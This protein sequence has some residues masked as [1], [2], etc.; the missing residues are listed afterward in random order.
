VKISLHS[1]SYAGLWGQHYLGVGDF[2]DKAAELGYDGVM[3]TAKRPHLSVLD[4]MPKELASLRSRIEAKNLRAVCLAGYTNFSADLD[5]SDIPLI[6]MQIA[7]VTELARMAQALDCPSVRIFTAYD[8][9]KA[10]WSTLVRTL[11]EC[12]RRAAPTIVGVQNHHDIAVDYETLFDLISEVD[13]PNCRAMF[14][15]WAPAIH[16]ADLA[17]AAKRMA[18]IT[19]HTT[20]ANYQPRP[21]FQY[22]PAAVSYR[23]LAPRM[24][25]VP[26]GEGFID[27]R[28]FLRDMQTAGFHGS[29]AYEMCSPLRGG[30]ELA[31][32][33]EY[34]RKFVEF[35]TAG[36]APRDRLA[37]AG[38]PA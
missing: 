17:A 21:R 12:A 25:A 29:I 26:I 19:V 37:S 31:N 7:H 18:G 15:A 23:A 1:I 13:E 20:V 34:A 2:I 6:E 22:D 24:Q 28:T 3:L 27:Y 36:E 30:G 32:L 8:H 4:W 16:G 5:H 10:Q 9:P 35:M 33:D 14:D 11:R 38:L